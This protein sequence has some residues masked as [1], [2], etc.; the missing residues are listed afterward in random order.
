MAQN[1]LGGI[2][3]PPETNFEA[4]MIAVGDMPRPRLRPLRRLGGKV[5]T[6]EQM[7]KLLRN[8]RLMI[9]EYYSRGYYLDLEI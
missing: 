9:P 3:D 6:P 8:G 7:R 1:G 2:S 4:R 5:P